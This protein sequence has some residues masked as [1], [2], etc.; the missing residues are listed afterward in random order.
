MDN[1]DIDKCP[2]CGETDMCKGRQSSYGKI[3]PLDSMWSIRFRS[4]TYYM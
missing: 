1:K 4:N 3:I 2:F